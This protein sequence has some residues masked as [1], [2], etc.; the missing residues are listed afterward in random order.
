MSIP[1]FVVILDQEGARYDIAEVAASAI[2]GGAD[3]VQI[4]EKT[5]AEAEVALIA[6]RVIE[7][8][9]DP[10]RVA[11]NG[12]P[13]IAAQLG[14][15]LHLPEAMTLDRDEL[16]LSPGALLSRSIHGPAP[17][18]DADYAILGSLFETSSK[19]GKAGLGCE[20][21][22]QL[23]R[24]CPIPVLAI[25]GIE[26]ERVRDVIRHGGNGVAVRSYVI[27]AADPE[28]AA[29]NIKRELDAWKR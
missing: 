15:H 19:P 6:I 12:F 8:I 18:L 1:R 17:A 7:A 25:G 29:R 22:E 14:T 23:A 21:F 28:R 16:D 26:P 20:R 11:V 13:A 2:R 9:G 24:V 5:L 3:I 27:S 4:R 10:L